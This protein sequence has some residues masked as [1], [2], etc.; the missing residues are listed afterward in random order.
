MESRRTELGAGRDA[1]ADGTIAIHRVPELADANR[2]VGAE[3]GH[4]RSILGRAGD[5]REQPGVDSRH[6]RG[7][8]R[9]DCSCERTIRYSHAPDAICS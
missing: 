5:D 1:G 9:H 4:E 3:H 8:R 6:G 2:V 7:R